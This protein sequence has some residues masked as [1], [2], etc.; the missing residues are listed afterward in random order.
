MK[1]DYRYRG[2]SGVL[3]GLR[4]FQMEWRQWSATLKALQ[5][6]VEDWDC[7]ELQFDVLDFREGR[8]LLG[9]GVLRMRQ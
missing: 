6:F 2:G 5:K 9:F 7:V 3:L 1:R 8:K 4:P